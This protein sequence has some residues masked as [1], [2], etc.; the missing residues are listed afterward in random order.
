MTFQH[1]K[2]SFFEWHAVNLSSYT[3]STDFDQ[4]GEV[5]DTTTYGA[6]N[7]TYIAGLKDGSFSVGFMWDGTAVTGPDVLFAA[8]LGTA[9]NF[10][11]RVNSGARSATNPGYTGSA[12]LTDWKIGM[13]VGDVTQGTADF[14]ISGVVTRNT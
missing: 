11:I 6:T 4:K 1:G 9:Q 10:E 5:A 3:T 14:Q 7:H 13:K 8:D 12:I 2:D